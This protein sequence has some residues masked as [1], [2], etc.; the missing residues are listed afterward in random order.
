[1]QQLTSRILVGVDTPADSRHLVRVASRLASSLD[2]ELHLVHV[3]LTRSTVQG[4][5]M[6]P[7]QRDSQQQEGEQLLAALAEQAAAVGGEVAGQHVRF[8]ER[9]ERELVRAQEQLAAGLLV[10]G[11]SRD[12]GV[13]RRL[14]GTPVSGTVR[15]SPGS[16]LVVR[17][18][19]GEPDDIL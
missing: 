16:V 8:G 6:T 11:T 4:R 3:R 10:V 2:A 7:A 12:A 18:P 19:A 5:P 1:M 13:A 14:L 15:R 17:E 9:I